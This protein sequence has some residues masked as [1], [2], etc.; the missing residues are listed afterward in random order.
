MSSLNVR[1]IIVGVISAAAGLLLT[2]LTLI[3]LGTNWAEFGFEAVFVVI[4][5]GVA[6]MI[7]LDYFLS[8][9]IL[10]D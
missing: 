7:W 6:I 10:P 8:A 9:E 1:R 3:I 5:L 4:S 2:Q